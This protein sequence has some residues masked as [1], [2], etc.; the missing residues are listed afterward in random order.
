MEKR[1]EPIIN[2][3][4]KIKVCIFVEEDRMPDAVKCLGEIQTVHNNI[5]I[6]GKCV[7]SLRKVAITSLRYL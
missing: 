2:M 6:G 4:R 5:F 7:F 3:I 1:L